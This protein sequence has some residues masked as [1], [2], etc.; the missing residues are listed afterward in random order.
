[1]VAEARTIYT[2]LGAARWLERI[3]QPTEMAT[4]G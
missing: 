2:E 4:A 3:Q 1:M